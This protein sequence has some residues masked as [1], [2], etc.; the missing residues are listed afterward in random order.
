MLLFRFGS[1]ASQSPTATR[2]P[3]PERVGGWIA[4]GDEELEEWVLKSVAADEYAMRR[5]AADGRTPVWVYIGL[6]GGRADG[7]GAHDPESCYPGQ[8]WEIVRSGSAIVPQADD[9]IHGK[10]L[11]VQRVN[12]EQEVLYWFQPARRWPTTGL[13]EQLLQ[14]LDAVTGRPQYAFVRVSAARQEGSGSEAD[15]IEFASG[16]APSIREGVERFKR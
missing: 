15:L 10:F 2:F 7:K 4:A 11:V 13:P 1:G 12:K 8:G 14:V 3:L 5:Y 6:Y 9:G 16:L